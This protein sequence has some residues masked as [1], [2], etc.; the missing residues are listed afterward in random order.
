[1][2]AELSV[3]AGTIAAKLR[4]AIC[5]GQ[6]SPNERLIEQD[7]AD[8]FKVNRAKVR[9]ALAV[10]D[11]EGLVVI[12]P[13]RGARVRVMTG[14]EALEIAET[15]CALEGM[16][17][18]Q[19]AKRATPAE[20]A[21]LRGLVDAMAACVDAGDLLK[22]S[23]VNGELHALISAISGNEIARNLLASLKSRV[24][25]F[26]FRAILTPGRAARSLQEHREIVD[27]ICAGD[28]GEASRLMQDHLAMARDALQKIID[29]S[30]PAMFG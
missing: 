1:L 22:Y 20:C 10:L 17:A 8:K 7:L 11:Q 29:E 23:D 14:R 24:V 2:E 27:A 25:R 4:T 28:A 19:A 30:K 16:L 15:R 26:Q 21:K 9:T 13:N 5:E 3:Q 18:A 6:F 12:E